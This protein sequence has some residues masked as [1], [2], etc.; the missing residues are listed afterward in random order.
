MGMWAVGDTLHAEVLL[1]QTRQQGCMAG[2]QILPVPQHRILARLHS[3]P[4]DWQ[5]QALCGKSLPLA[6]CSCAACLSL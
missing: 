1:R 6:V 5:L 2:I 4:L 3:S